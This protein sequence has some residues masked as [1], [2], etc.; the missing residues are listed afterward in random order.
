MFGSFNTYIIWTPVEITKF[1]SSW[2]TKISIAESH[3]KKKYLSNYFLFW[4][5]SLQKIANGN[6]DANSTT[7]IYF[8]VVLAQNILLSVIINSTGP[9]IKIMQFSFAVKLFTS[10]LSEIMLTCK[11]KWYSLI[12]FKD[13]PLNIKVMV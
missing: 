10:F 5:N 1:I 12:P 8:V 13:T 4:L 3:K 7:L 2:L 6:V 11:W 9:I